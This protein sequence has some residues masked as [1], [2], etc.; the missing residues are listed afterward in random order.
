VGFELNTLGHLADKADRSQVGKQAAKKVR[1]NLEDHLSAA[2]NYWLSLPE[3][4]LRGAGFHVGNERSSKAEAGRLKWV[5]VKPGVADWIFTGPPTTAIE[6]KWGKNKQSPTQ[7]AWA[8]VFTSGWAG[9]ID[10]DECGEGWDGSGMS[11]ETLKDL[12]APRYCICRTLFSAADVIHTRGL[13]RAPTDRK[14]LKASVAIVLSW[15]IV[16]HKV[17]LEW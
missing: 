8:G 4:E 12:F 13:L 3:V 17:E 5:G 1:Q 6:L 2:F 7:K 14:A 11:I 9:Y 16:K 15:W 10:P